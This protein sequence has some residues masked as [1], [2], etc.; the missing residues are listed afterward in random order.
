MVPEEIGNPEEAEK[1]KAFLELTIESNKRIEEA[2][3]Q[4]NKKI[5]TIFSSAATLVAIVAGLGYFVL[6][7]GYTLGTLI[8]VTASLTCLFLALAVGFS[9]HELSDFG[10]LIPTQI[11]Q[12]FK[13]EPMESL[14]S[15][16]ALTLDEI[17]QENCAIIN[18]KERWIKLMLF[19]IFL[20]LAFAA[21]GF[22]FFGATALK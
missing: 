2:Y 13:E 8:F 20:G 3:D 21:I 5:G 17:T 4:V 18:S 14:R 15:R 6:K 19:F 10:Y 16:A 11:F 1:S 9:L 7:E 22:V 12:K